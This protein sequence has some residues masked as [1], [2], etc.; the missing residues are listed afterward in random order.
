MQ[1]H[2]VSSEIFVHLTHHLVEVGACAVHLVD[3]GDTGHAV[4]VGLVPHRLALWLHSAYGAEHC[5]HAVDDA[6]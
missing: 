2:S 3:E 1:W 5:H 4:F 6:Q